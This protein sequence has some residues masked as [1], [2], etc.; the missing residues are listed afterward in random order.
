MAYKLH[1]QNS[2]CSFLCQNPRNI[3][4]FYPVSELR[5]SVRKLLPLSLFKD[6]WFELRHTWLVALGR[7]GFSYQLLVHQ[8]HQH[9]NMPAQLYCST[10]RVEPEPG[11]GISYDEKPNCKVLNSY[12]STMTTLMYTAEPLKRIKPTFFEILQIVKPKF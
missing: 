4:I 10:W 12:Q 8:M 1:C 5:N 11:H 3:N 9:F 2:S 6:F 7:L